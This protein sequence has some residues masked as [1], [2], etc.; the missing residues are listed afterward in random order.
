MGKN[1]KLLLWLCAMAMALPSQ[2][3]E[4]TDLAT[5]PVQSATVPIKG[6]AVGA[7]AQRLTA[8]EAPVLKPVAKSVR[9]APAGP[10]KAIGSVDDLAGQY[11]MTFGSLVSGSGQGGNS[12]T[13]SPVGTDSVLLSNFWTAGVNVKAAVDLKAGTITIPCQY[14]YTHAAYGELDLATVKPGGKIDYDT[15]ITGTFEAD[16][17][18]SIT[19]WWAICIR[20]GKYKDKYTFAGYNTLLEPANAKMHVELIDTTA[21]DWN[22]I[23]HQESQNLVTVK[24]FGNNGKTVEIVLHTDSTLTISQQLVWE[25]GSIVGDFYTH[26]VDWNTNEIVSNTITGQVTDS[27]LSWGDWIISNDYYFA[28]KYK[29]ALIT[30]QNYRIPTLSVTGWQGSGTEADPYQIKTLDDLVLLSQRVNSDSNRHWGSATN[31]H[32]KTYE[33]KHFALLDDINMT[34]YRFDPIGHNYQQRFAGTFDGGGHVLKGLNVRTGEAGY[35]GL[36]GSID[37]SAVIKNVGL[38]N[39]TVSSAFYATAGL[40]AYG[41]GSSIEN[42]RVSGNISSTGV[43]AG[44]VVGLGQN[45]SGCSFEGNLASSGGINGGIAGQVYGTI[46]DC[47]AKGTVTAAGPSAGMTAGGVVGTLYGPEAKCQRSYFW[48]TVD[49]SYHTSLLVGGVAGQCSRGQIDACFAV[50]SVLA[51]G[52]KAAAGGVV[53]QLQGSLTNSYATGSVQNA[54]AKTTGGITGTV[55]PYVIDDDTAQSV[56]KQCYFTGTLSAETQ[57]YDRDTEV[58]ETLG[59]VA[60]GSSPE[61]DGVYFDRQMFSCTSRQHSALTSELT[62]ASGPKGFSADVWTFTEGYYPRLKGIENNDAA[63]LGASSLMLNDAVPDVFSHVSANAGL[64]L[65]SP[66]KARFMV[67]GKLTTAGRH[68]SFVADSVKLR[69]T[70][71]QDSLVIYNPNDMTMAQRVIVL[72]AAPRCFDGLGTETS[73]YLIKTKA[74]LMKLGEITTSKRQCYSGVHFLQTADIDMQQD[75][76]F[77]GIADALSDYAD[78]AWAGIYDGGGYTLHNVKLQFVEWQEKPTTT[79]LGTPLSQDGTRSSMQKGLFG[80]VANE[81]VVRNLTLASDCQIELWGI[82]GAIAGSSYGLIENCRNYAPVKGYAN[83]IGGLV[84]EVNKGAVVRG[85]LNAGTVTTGYAMAGGIAGACSGLIEGCQNVGTVEARQLSTFM[86]DELTR[87]AGGI[88]GNAYGA[89]MRDV[90]NAGHIFARKNAGGIAGSMDADAVMQGANDLSHALSYGTVFAANSTLAGGISGSAC[91]PAAKIYDVTYDQQITGL[92][93]AAGSTVQGV[94]AATTSMLV[95]GPDLGSQADTLW[96]HKAERYPVLKRFENDALVQAASQVVISIAEGQ[97]VKQLSADA[98]LSTPEGISW[99]LKRGTAFKVSGSTLQVPAVTTVA[100][101][102]LTATL[103]GYSKPF[104]LK[105]VSPMPLLGSG[106]EADPWQLRNA[107]EWDTLA[108]YIAMTEDEL[109]GCYIKVMRDISFADTTFTPLAGDGITPFGGTLLGDGH[110]VSGISHTATATYQG[111]IGTVGTTG[112]VKNLTLQGTI[113]SDKNYTGGFTGRLKGRLEDC[114]NKVDVTSTA[115]GTGGFAAQADDG[116]QLLRC[117]NE[118]TIT[119]TKTSLAGFVAMADGALTLTDCVNKGKITMT[120]KSSYTAGLVAYGHGTTFTRCSNQA[121][122]T[123]KGNN[124]AGLQAYTLGTDPVTFI[125]CSN[126]ASITGLSTVAGLIGGQ[127]TSG[128]AHSPVLASGCTN[129]RTITSSSSTTSGIAGLFAYIAGGSVITDCHNTGKVITTNGRYAGGI[130]GYAVSANKQA[131]SIVVRRCSNT[132]VI[133]GYTYAAGI[134]AYIPGYTRIDSC[135]NTGAISAN[136]YAGGIGNVVY[137]YATINDCWNSGD[138]T[139]TATAAGGILGYSNNRSEANRCFNTGNIKAGSMAGG[140]GGHGK[141]VWTNCYNRGTVS[142]EAYCGG[143]QGLPRGDVSSPEYSCSFYNCYNAGR[144]INNDSTVGSLVGYTSPDVWHP[145]INQVQGTSYVTDWGTY[146]IDTIGGTPVTIAQL[147]K[148]TSMAGQWSF[149]DDY[150]FPVI[151]G[152][153]QNECARAFAA[154]VVL[155]D[156]DTYTNVAHSFWVGQPDGVTW[157]DSKNLVWFGDGNVAAATRASQDED[158]L[159]ASCGKFAAKWSVK[160]NTTTGIDEANLTDKP[161]LSRTYYNVAGVQVTGPEPGQVLIEVTRYTDGS[162]Q[163]RKVIGKN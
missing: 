71:G 7:W 47:W 121:T 106:T 153:E 149:G 28:G 158:V 79:S 114:V 88:V 22:V 18:I 10:R 29:N 51:F 124:V 157:T 75:T 160:F 59:Q 30:G 162:T 111:A 58:R 34:G 132:A 141:T 131:D 76:T 64:H 21:Q 138:V 95:G 67:G 16:G 52:T 62:S 27:T 65:M 81:G 25:G 69:G 116:A 135:Y 129:S 15:P 70:F 102:T 19:S 39:A 53:G 142:A 150:S 109:E 9:K 163:S 46:S 57:L 66:V 122:V 86:T 87:E 61:V 147:A 134:G 26:Q 126:Q 6:T 93:A 50:A 3:Q 60:E 11:V 23:V 54:S 49:G 84:G 91:N 155:R 77:L 42:C 145:G 20:T 120:A 156:S 118:A 85:C 104:S 8:I 99:T 13:V 89:V 143:L 100:T 133:S 140:L 78:L 161:V 127:A 74:D 2:A 123:S 14:A 43:V 4:I 12:V 40:V 112:V 125:D 72:Q 55:R 110:T 56:V 148:T 119:S 130:W 63:S 154:A 33:G 83:T 115:P 24:N 82:G 96:S 45:V 36:F 44:G 159:T 35:A 128:S 90:V 38:M 136:I 73:P 94:K 152:Y 98:T 101:D 137:N 97:T 48:G 113:S 103:G 17:T 68:M 5:A 151:E 1:L 105:D 117:T 80:Q 139:V 146:E 144:V 41:P 32:T 31:P 37:S 108:A 92:G 107:A